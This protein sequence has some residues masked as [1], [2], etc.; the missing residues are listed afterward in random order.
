MHDQGRWRYL[1][2]FQHGSFQHRL[3]PVVQT[4]DARRGE[5]LLRSEL[6]DASEVSGTQLGQFHFADGL[7]DVADGPV[8]VLRRAVAIPQGV[9]G[10]VGL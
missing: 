4:Q 10:K 5:S 2:S 6:M 3:Q 8:D 9:L 1:Q 7:D